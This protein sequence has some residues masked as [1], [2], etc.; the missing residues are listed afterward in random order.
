MSELG[1]RLDADTLRLVRQLEV[2][3]E[4]VWQA[5]TT[6]DGIAAWLGEPV[7]IEAS[8]DGRFEVELTPGTLMDG[9]VLELEPDRRLVIL[10][11]ETSGGA[12]LP[13]GTQEGDRSAI[14]FELAPHEAAGTTRH[15]SS[16]TATS[17]A[18]TR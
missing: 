11:H 5:I 16:P 17:A 4:R 8:P 7:L 14:T 6:P 12:S 15:W 18:P 13:Y 3:Q 9:R 1:E 2:P 10:W